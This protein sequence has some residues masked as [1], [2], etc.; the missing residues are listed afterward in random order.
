M[1]VSATVRFDHAE[2]RLFEVAHRS[3]NIAFPVHGEPL[4]ETGFTFDPDHPYRRRFPIAN[5]PVDRQRLALTQIVLEQVVAVCVQESARAF[6]PAPDGWPATP[7]GHSVPGGPVPLFAA[8]FDP[9]SLIAETRLTQA[10]EALVALALV[11]TAI[12]HA[13][14]ELKV[15]STPLIAAARMF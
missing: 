5:E 3:V 7:M 4:T 2:A 10:E 15:D 8:G 9:F 14:T 11:R 6:W 1:K 13:G 12:V